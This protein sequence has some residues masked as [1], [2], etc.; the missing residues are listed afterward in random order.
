MKHL[1]TAAATAL[2][3]VPGSLCAQDAAPSGDAEAGGER[4]NRQCIA[5]HVV[6]NA[7]GEVLAGRN[8]KTGPNLYGVA[9][10]TPGTYGGFNYSKSMVEA[11]EAGLTWSEENFV[12]YVQDPIPWLRETLDDKRARGKM[13][14]KVRSEEEALNIFAFLVSLGPDGGDA[15]EATEA[16][17]SN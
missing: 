1:L 11:G 5:C 4:F 16:P 2:L 15:G 17:A 6:E 12:G 13:A 7:D 8:A 3:A 14:F 9:G 10:R